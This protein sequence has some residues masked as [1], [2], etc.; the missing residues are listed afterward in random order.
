MKKK[1]RIGDEKSLLLFFFFHKRN[2]IPNKTEIICS[3]DLTVQPSV[4][5]SFSSHVQLTR[6]QAVSHFSIFP[7]QIYF[8]TGEY[9]CESLKQKI[10]KNINKRRHTFSLHGSI[11]CT[12]ETRP[13]LNAP[14]LARQHTAHHAQKVQLSLPRRELTRE[15]NSRDLIATFLLL[16]HPICECCSELSYTN[17]R[18][19][20]ARA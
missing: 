4:T 7:A 20:L 6:F 19:S 1:T 18:A 17:W 2:F 5:D 10:K 14:L 16:L 9:I 3:K 8:V 12:D 15:E 13:A 11:I